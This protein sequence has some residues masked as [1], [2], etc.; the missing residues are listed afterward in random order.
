[1]SFV[2]KPGRGITEKEAKATIGEIAKEVGLT[3][4]KLVGLMVSSFFILIMGVMMVVPSVGGFFYGV[5]PHG[6]CLVPLVALL[7]GL[8]LCALGATFLVLPVLM[9]A[10]GVSATLLA[11]LENKT[12]RRIL[13]FLS[14]TGVWVNIALLLALMVSSVTGGVSFLVFLFAMVIAHL[15]LWLFARPVRLAVKKA[16]KSALPSR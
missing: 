4:K 9:V 7:W 11:V 2:R 8:Y 13:S 12:L 3:T 5:C 1:M 15:A 16:V 10:G 14:N 6:V